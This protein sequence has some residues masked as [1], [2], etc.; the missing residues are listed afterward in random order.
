MLA[1]LYF[2]SGRAAV[3]I[4]ARACGLDIGYERLELASFDEFIFDGLKV[5]DKERGIGLASKHAVIRPSWRPSS[6]KDLTIGFVLTEVRFVKQEAEKDDA[7]DKVSE[8]IAIPFKS[9]WAYKRI[10][11]SI[12]PS[13]EKIIAKDLIAEGDDLKLSIKGS[14]D[15]KKNKVDSDLVIYF[16]QNLTSKI[17]EELAKALLVDEKDGWKSLSVRLTGDYSKPSIRVSG[18]LFRLNVKEVWRP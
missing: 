10:S 14:L 2:I 17:P 9:R 18:R 3:Y 1:A 16:S 6:F 5:I 15:P 12:Q 7:F 11:G 13:A 8:L 4:L